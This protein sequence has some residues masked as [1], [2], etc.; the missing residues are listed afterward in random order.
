MPPPIIA[1]T[2]IASTI[3]PGSRYWMHGREQ[4]DDRERRDEHAS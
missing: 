4:D 2:K 3:V 1:D